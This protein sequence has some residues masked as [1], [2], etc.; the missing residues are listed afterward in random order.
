MLMA[1]A[2]MLIGQLPYPEKK[3]PPAYISPELCRTIQPTYDFI[4]KHLSAALPRCKPGNMIPGNPTDTWCLTDGRDT[5][6]VYTL[7]GDRFQLDLSRVSGEFQVQWFNP[8]TGKVT[9][10]NRVAA[11]KHA[12]FTP[13]SSNDWALHL[14]RPLRKAP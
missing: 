5:Y 12:E 1:G 3:D 10:A 2:S 4:R 8:R 9:G 7:S 14:Q 6:L 11:G 13:P